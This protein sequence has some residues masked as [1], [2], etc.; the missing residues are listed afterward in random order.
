MADLKEKAISLLSSTTVAMGANNTKA[1]LFTVPVGFKCIVTEVV[2]HSLDAATACGDDNDFGKGAS[3]AGWKDTVNL[4]TVD[5][6]D[7][8]YRVTPSTDVR[9]ETIFVAGDAFG[10]QTDIGSSTAGANA[11][12]DVLGYLISA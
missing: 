6:T 7:D 1:T 12:V 2:I 11:T 10:I 8:Y 3:A 5:G 4:S 9:I